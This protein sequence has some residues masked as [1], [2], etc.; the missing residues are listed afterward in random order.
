MVCFHQLGLFI[1]QLGDSWGRPLPHVLSG[2]L[3]RQTQEVSTRLSDLCAPRLRGQGE[4]QVDPWKAP[5]W[6]AGL[7]RTLAGPVPVFSS[8]K[9]EGLR[10]SPGMEASIPG[11]GHDPFS[12]FPS[13]SAVHAGS[14]TG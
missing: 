2:E 13:L 7:T 9:E 6:A 1:V 11:G 8:Q 12:L 3:G 10:V 5:H 4:G 14:W